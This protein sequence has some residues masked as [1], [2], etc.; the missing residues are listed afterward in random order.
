MSDVWKIPYLAKLHS[1]VVV[2][3]TDSKTVFYDVKASQESALQVAQVQLYMY[4]LPKAQGEHWCG[5]KFEEGGR[6]RGR[7]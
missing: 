1:D 3:H 2:A 7:T 6:I 5:T 4:L